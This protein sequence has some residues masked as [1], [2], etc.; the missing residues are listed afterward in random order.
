MSATLNLPAVDGTVVP[1]TLREG[2]RWQAPSAPFRTRVAYAAA[3]V[4]VDP[5]RDVDVFTENAKAVVRIR[6]GS[7]PIDWPATSESRSARMARPH[8]LALNN[9]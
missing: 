7:R 2:T 3:H 6:M 9:A 8:G 1:F 4:V 5:R